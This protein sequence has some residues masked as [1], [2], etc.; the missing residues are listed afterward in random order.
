[1]GLL[2]GLLVFFLALFLV[3]PFIL[4]GRISREEPWSDDEQAVALRE[5]QGELCWCNKC[6]WAG[7]VR[8]KNGSY[9][10]PG[11]NY[12]AAPVSVLESWAERYRAPEEARRKWLEPDEAKQRWAKGSE[13]GA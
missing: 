10:H 4:S 9:W 5:Q 1:M 8:P 12:S 11:C 13:Y 6:G 7:R 3:S 2:I